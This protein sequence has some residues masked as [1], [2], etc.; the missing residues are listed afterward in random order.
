MHGGMDHM[1]I[2]V[3][4]YI[5]YYNSAFNSG[6]LDTKVTGSSTTY[7]S[8]CIDIFTEI[9]PNDLLL[10]NG[11]LPGHLEMYQNRLIGVK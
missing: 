1:D 5:T 2:V 4:I 3:I 10:V 7:E 11:P 9:N 8:Y 6:Q